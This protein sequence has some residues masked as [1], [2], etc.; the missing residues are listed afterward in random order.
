MKN[1][2]VARQTRSAVL[3]AAVLLAS[4]LMV[5]AA[6]T[7][8]AED[9]LSDAC[10]D[11]IS[12]PA[13]V[14]INP[15][16]QEQLDLPVP[17]TRVAVGEPTIADVT[18]VDA[19]SLLLLA[20]KPGD[21]S[22][23]V[24]TKCRRD[25]IKVVV[26]VPAAS[27]ALQQ[28]S[29][30]QTPEMLAQLPSQVQVDIRFVELSRSRLSDL[31][32]R[33]LGTRSSNLFTS[34]TGGSASGSAGIGSLTASS[35]PLDGNAFNIVW[36]GGSSRFLTAINLLEQ[37]GYA[38]TLSQPSLVAMSGQ[39]ASFLAGGEVPIPVPQTGSGGGGIT[40]QYKEFG[41]RLMLTPTIV[42]TNQI[43]LKVAPEVSDLDF[44]NAITIQGSTVPALRIR[45]TDTSI[46]LADGES[47]I[48]SGLITR[49]TVNNADKLP[50]LSDIPIL[51][52][53]FRS[54]RFQTDDRELLMIVT[55]R[56]VRPFAAD[57]KLP[58]LPGEALRTYQPTP[59][60]LFWQGSDS[61]NRDASTGFSR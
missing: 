39:S 53:F 44:A 13:S 4:L 58:P 29:Q 3:P 43:F 7:A 27:S 55:P 20:R 6:R 19:R 47:F 36:G 60:Q 34:P 26:K 5:G 50:G 21:T 32:A 10:Q 49:S 45:R 9:R 59:G 14:T 61:P 1:V 46:S 31:G 24:W 56:L 54:N 22:L 17:V 2:F 41:V 51:G 8:L 30:K 38:Y 23:L 33:L 52:A 25:P 11:A 28:L 57:A 48:I 40:I 12:L 42:S 18:L 15:G 16:Y 35:F 37:T